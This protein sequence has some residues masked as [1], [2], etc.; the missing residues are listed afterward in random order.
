M[1]KL[2]MVTRKHKGETYHF[3]CSAK[4]LTEEEIDTFLGITT[5]FSIPDGLRNVFA[6]DIKQ[7]LDFCCAKYGVQPAQI[8]AEAQRL[9]PQVNIGLMLK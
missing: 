3:I 2:K 6:Q 1:A 4:Q 7:G 8:R 5:S 9:F